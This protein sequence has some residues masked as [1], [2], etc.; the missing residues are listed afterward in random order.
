MS[1]SFQFIFPGFPLK[2]E[3]AERI[4]PSCQPIILPLIILL[5]SIFLMERKP[6]ILNAIRNVHK[7]VTI[8]RGCPGRCP[9]GCSRS[10]CCSGSYSSPSGSCTVS[11]RPLSGCSTPGSCLACRLARPCF[12]RLGCSR[13][14]CLPRRLARPC[15]GCLACACCPSAC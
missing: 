15:S 5:L 9:P 7:A 14:S 4:A 8:S 12:S 3:L 6:F 11:S 13:S 10:S 2:A 1:Y